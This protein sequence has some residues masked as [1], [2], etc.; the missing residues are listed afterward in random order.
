MSYLDNYAAPHI[1]AAN[2]PADA[3]TA[4]IRRT[5]LHLAGALLLFTGL[6][7]VLVNSPFAEIAVANPPFFFRIFID[8][9]LFEIIIV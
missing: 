9:Q 6:E 7:F 8:H 1:M 2:A 4:F 5:Y 3:R